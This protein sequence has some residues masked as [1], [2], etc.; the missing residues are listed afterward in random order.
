MPLLSGLVL[1]VCALLV[2]AEIVHHQRLTSSVVAWRA[3]A[4]LTA[5][6]LPPVPGSRSLAGF[7]GV[8]HGVRWRWEPAARRILFARPLGVVAG[9]R[10]YPAGYLRRADDGSWTVHWKAT[11][12]SLLACVF[13]FACIGALGLVAVEGEW[14]GLAVVPAAAVA[15]GGVG[16]IARIN[17]RAT[18]ERLVLPALAEALQEQLDLS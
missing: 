15:L 11:P 9:E 7:E 8:R 2:A 6:V 5:V 14:M 4:D 10:G 17:A 16:F 18:L 3:R 12:I 1:L 13:L